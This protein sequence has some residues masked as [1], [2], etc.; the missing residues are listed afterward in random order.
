M[1]HEIIAGVPMKIAST[2]CLLEKGKKPRIQCV[3]CE[4]LFPAN[5]KKQLKTGGI[6]RACKELLVAE[7]VDKYK[8]LVNSGLPFEKRWTETRIDLIRYYD[9]EWHSMLREALLSVPEPTK[10]CGPLTLRG[11]RRKA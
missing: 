6:C 4:S 2:I 10:P 11:L 1:A 3:E 8:G 9:K 7:A 5:G